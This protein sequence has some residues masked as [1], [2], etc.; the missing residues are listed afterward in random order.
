[1]A[2]GD[3]RGKYIFVTGA[4]RG[5]GRQIAIEL[6]AA[7][8]S[9]ML[10]YN[11]RIDA[12]NE[13]RGLCESN[14]A[15]VDVVQGDVGTDEGILSMVEAVERASNQ[16]NGL[17]N[18]AGIY[19]GKSLE[20]T[21]AN[22][23]DLM[24]NTNLRST[25]LLTKHLAPVLVD[26]SAIVN[27]SSILGMRAAGGAH[28]YQVSK[29]GIVHLTKSLALELAPRIR[30]NAVAPGFIM[31]DINRSGWENDTFKKNVENETPMARWGRPR[32]IAKAVRFLMSEDANFIT[33]QILSVDGGKG[34]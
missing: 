4:S 2:F 29:A 24:I 34:I 5:I 25:F 32:D 15:H 28:E 17:V 12:I 19:F 3:L 26:N 33:G 7:G 13:T 20:E 9:L 1:M 21:S 18:N 16:I 8:A 10:H 30:V 31:T 14:G 22:D 23:W 11:Q 6:S 27:I